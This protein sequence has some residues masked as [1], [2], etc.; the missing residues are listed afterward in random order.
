MFNSLGA[1]KG[2]ERLPCVFESLIG[3]YSR[4]MVLLDLS[5]RCVCLTLMSYVM[6]SEAR[7]WMADKDFE[8]V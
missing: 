3:G 4:R 5:I 8:E 6:Y 1:A 2:K 7:R